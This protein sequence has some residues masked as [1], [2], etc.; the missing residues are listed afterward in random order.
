MVPPRS[1]VHERKI[2]SEH[3]VMQ[4]MMGC[5]LRS[6][7]SFTILQEH[8][9]SCLSST[10]PGSGSSQKP[11]ESSKVEHAVSRLWCTVL[12]SGTSQR[13]AA[14]NTASCPCLCKS[15]RRK[16]VQDAWSF[17]LKR[18]SW[19]FVCT[20]IPLICTDSLINYSE[21]YGHTRKS[22]VS[23]ACSK[24]GQFD[25]A[26]LPFAPPFSLENVVDAP[27]IFRLHDKIFSCGTYCVSSIGH[28]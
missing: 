14:R 12:G 25:T 3:W 17:P 13:P 5:F 7:F 10:V 2:S 27:Q 22:K 23:V 16:N 26:V 1:Y 4:P 8:M 21:S 24:E 19:A 28:E 20:Y 18:R 11:T 9:V 15:S 6:T